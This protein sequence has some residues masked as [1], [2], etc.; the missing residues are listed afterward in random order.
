MVPR[1]LK[2]VDLPKLSRCKKPPE[3]KRAGGAFLCGIATHFVCMAL[4][5][6]IIFISDTGKSIFEPI[7]VLGVA[8]PEASKVPQNQ[9]PLILPE[10]SIPVVPPTFQPEIATE[11]SQLNIEPEPTE[12]YGA[13]WPTKPVV[14]KKTPPVPVQKKIVKA[15]AQPQPKATPKP[16]PVVQKKVA[17]VPARPKYTPKPTYP[18]SARAKKQSGTAMVKM[19][20]SADGKVT[21]ASIARSSG[22]P[23]LD[24]AAIKATKRWKF[25]PARDSSGNARASSVVVP[26]NFSL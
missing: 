5:S 19:N 25:S 14:V 23:A 22:H 7:R 16:K 9:T 4:I 20:V 18:S 17:T 8:E 26:I 12:F 3:A 6:S 11:I 21:S 10:I 24:A 15:I 13:M 1:K 2:L